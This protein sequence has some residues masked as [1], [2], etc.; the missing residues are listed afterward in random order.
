MKLKILFLLIFSSLYSNAQS[1]FVFIELFTSQGDETSPVAEE[2]LYRT[3]A[4][5]R[6]NGMKIVVLEYHVDYWNRLGWKDPLSKFHF[7]KR[8]ENYSRVLAE[9]EL[10][11]PEVVING[12]TSF[13][14]TK[15][16]TLKEEIKKASLQTIQFDFTVS[17][18]SIA[19]DTLY[20]T[21][22]T[23]Q[24]NQ[25]AVFRFAITESGISTKIGAG[26]NS[27]KTLVNNYVV[28]LLHSSDGIK[29]STQ[30][31]VPVKGIKFNS[32]VEMIAFVQ[33]KQS[34]KILGVKYL[35]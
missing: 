5:E 35:K 4:Q 21:Y 29:K 13:S 1:N 24:A 12:T 28:R 30:V 15:E 23:K 6:K 31:K 2:I 10:Y 25:N 8:Q 34:M 14:G 32:N 9:K 33:S 3:V 7:T 17:K 20:I 19:N 11:T 18:D 16:T 27:N 26:E 22:A